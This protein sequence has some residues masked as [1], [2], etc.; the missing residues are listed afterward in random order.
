MRYHLR[1]HQHHALVRQRLKQA[2]SLI[3]I[4]H[5]LDL[6]SAAVAERGRGFVYPPVSDPDQDCLYQLRSGSLS[7]AG[8]ALS[9]GGVSRKDLEPLR[10]QSIRNL[11]AQGRMPV[12]LTLGAAMVLDAAERTQDRGH[13]W[14]D[15]LAQARRVAV[16]Y[17]QLLPNHALDAA[18]APS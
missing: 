11:Y 13:N 16:R 6:L 14:G 15:S 12:T 18:S 5:A 3:D 4:G 8:H 7:L 9:L 1:P 17:V 10:R 2:G